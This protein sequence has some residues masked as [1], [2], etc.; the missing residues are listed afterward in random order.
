MEAYMIESGNNLIFPFSKEIY[1]GPYTVY[2][3]TSSCYSDSIES[4]GWAIGEVLYDMEDV[5]LICKILKDIELITPGSIPLFSISLSGKNDWN[6]QRTSS[7][8][9]DYWTARNYSRN[10]GGETITHMVLSC[11]QYI[12]FLSNQTAIRD[13]VIKLRYNIDIAPDSVYRERYSQA[14]NRLLSSSLLEENK[15]YV[16]KILTKYKNFTI[17]SCPI[18]YAVKSDPLWFKEWVEGIRTRDYSDYVRISIDLAAITAVPAESLVAKVVYTGGIK[19]WR[20]HTG[21]PPP[22]PWNLS[23]FHTHYSEQLMDLFADPQGI[24]YKE[25]TSNRL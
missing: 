5:R 14:L 25:N 19:Y 24:K 6:G 1:Y 8:A 18:V 2:H 9:S 23:S 3:G 15:T 7:F 22:I 17:D 21:A 13:Q 20:F 16:M 10:I 12:E 4:R 11:E